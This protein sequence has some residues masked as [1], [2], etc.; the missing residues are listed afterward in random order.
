MRYLILSLMFFLSATAAQAAILKS[1]PLADLKAAIIQED[2]KGANGLAKDLLKK[3][4]T[5]EQ[6]IQAQYYLGLSFLRLSEYP[7]AYETFKKL[8][9]DRPDIETYDKAEVGIIDALYLQGQYENALKE[10][11]GL[12]ARRRDSEQ[13]SLFCLKAARANLKLARWNKAR[14][15]L[16]KIIGDYPESFEADVARGLL[17]EKQYFA[18]QVGSFNDE[19]RAR[20]LMQELLD[21]KEYAYIVE[22]KSAE[23][24]LYFRVR[25]GQLTALKDAQDLEKKL[26][27][28]GYPTLIYP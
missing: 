1:D 3:D 9:S 22:T 2:F 17:E 16:E 28:L 11:T 12:I 19:A 20:K 25:A 24:R 7:K 4:L 10:V 18:V 14:D 27:G 5:R 26:S 15:M 6:S 8:L 23:G 13:M 21:R